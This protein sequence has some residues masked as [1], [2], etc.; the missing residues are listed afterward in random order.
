MIIP[1]RLAAETFRLPLKFC[2]I[3]YDMKYMWYDL[4]GT[5][6]TTG[7]ANRVQLKCS[8][9]ILFVQNWYCLQM[10][11][12]KKDEVR[13]KKR[14]GQEVAARANTNAIQKFLFFSFALSVIDG[15]MVRCF[16]LHLSTQLKTAFSLSFKTLY[17]MWLEQNLLNRSF[18]ESHRREDRSDLAEMKSCGTKANSL[19]RQKKKKNG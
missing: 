12:I 14:G 16:K 1:C 8:L 7:T 13:W 4:F 9:F 10:S 19:E 11:I 15:G 17:K 3:W 18:T 6:E 2:L 5:W